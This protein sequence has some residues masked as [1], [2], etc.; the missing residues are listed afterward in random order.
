MVIWWLTDGKAGHVAQAQGLF[1]ALRRQGLPIQVVE[2]P[3]VDC[4]RLATVWYWLSQ[5]RLGHLP[6]IC[7]HAAPPRMILGVGHS[8]HWMLLL[9]GKIYP[10][11]RTVVLMKPSLP[12]AWF[13]LVIMPE[14]DQPIECETVLATKG[15]LNPLSNEQRHHPR[16]VLL[17]IGGA[18]KRHGFDTDAIILQLQQLLDQLGTQQTVLLTTSRRTPNDLVEQPAIQALSQHIQI[19]PVDHTPHGWLF[20]QLQ[21]AESVWVTED[22]VSMLYEALTAGCQVGVLSM[23]RIKPDR[24]TQAIDQLIADGVVGTLPQLVLGRALPPAAQFAE[25]DRAA[26]WLNAHLRA[27]E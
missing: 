8:T 5:G 7:Q 15:V 10:K 4:S 26:I 25:A 17:L 1:A 12:L 2:I 23:P 19:F 6:E 24:I 11:A 9:L 21:L 18:S 27:V 20:E 16:R 14:H 22:S 13:D 3:I